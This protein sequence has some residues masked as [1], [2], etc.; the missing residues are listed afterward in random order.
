MDNN[1]I[2][3]YAI[4]DANVIDDLP[5]NLLSITAMDALTHAIEASTASNRSVMTEMFALQA[6]LE[7]LENIVPATDAAFSEEIRKKSRER[8]HVAASIAGVSITNSC[9]GIVHSYD[10]PGPYFNLPHGVVCSLMLPHTMELIGSH[11]SYA[12]LAARLGYSG[13]EEQKS[14]ALI[15]HIRFIQKF[16]SL[17][18]HFDKTGIDREEFFSCVPSWAKQSLNAFATKASPAN[19]TYEKGIA[20]YRSCYSAE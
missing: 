15:E 4:L 17:P 20:L 16:L 5:D 9:T 11:P 7:L 18:S 3:H 13:N 6:A 12:V 1:L 2:P 19:M 14:I 8:V 10:H